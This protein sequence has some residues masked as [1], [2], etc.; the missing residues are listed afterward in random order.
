MKKEACFVHLNEASKQLPEEIIK[1]G[2]A[3]RVGM[4][5]VILLFSCPFRLT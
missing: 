1:R 4:S 2:I 5:D 3:A